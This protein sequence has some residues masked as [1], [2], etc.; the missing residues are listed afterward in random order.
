M[1]AT[2][3]RPNPDE[4]LVRVQAEERQEARGKLQ[5]FLGYAAGVG[6]TYAMLEAARQ[7]EAQGVD[8]VVG[9]VETHG[10]A[11]TD[12]LLTGL[13]IIPRRQVEYRQTTV[14]EMDMDAVLARRPQLALVDEFAHTNAP[15]S[16]HP[17][18]YHD[19][20]E[21]LEAGIDVYTTLNI[22]HLESLND[23]VAQ[24]T[25]VVVRETLPDS[26]LD[27]AA[28]ITLVDLPPDELIQRLHDG[29]VYVPDTAA[30]A[31]ERFFR[32]GNLTALREMALRRAAGRVDEQMLAYM[33]TRAIL[34]PWPAGERLLVCVSTSSLGERLVRSARRLADE[35]GAEWSAIHVETGESRRAPEEMR[36]RVTRTLRLAED[37]GAKVVT[38]PGSSVAG[39]VLDYARTH[40]IT[41]II[42]G[43]PLRSR[44][45]EWLRGAIVDQLIRSSGPID[46][47]VVSSE[48]QASSGKSGDW[49]P[50]R[51]W[52]R[53]LQSTLLVAAA[54]LVS[55]PFS[56]L[57]SPVN[58][59]MLYLVVVVVSAVFLGRG[60]SILAS[61]LS[62]LAFDF[63]FVPPHL[64]FAV[65]DTEYILTFIG[66]FLVGLVISTLATRAREQADAARFSAEQ[67]TELYELSRDLAAVYGLDDILRALIRH[68]QGTFGREGVI[69]LPDHGR[70]ASTVGNG[71]LEL[72]ENELAVGD[73]VL[74]H[75]EPAGRNT[76][77]LPGAQLRYLPLKTAR[78]VL[79]VLGIRGS[80]EVDRYLTPEQERLMEAFAS[81]A[82]VAIERAQ[83]AEQAR[84]AQVLQGAE[85]LQT[86]LLNSISHDLRTPLVSIT[87]ALSSLQDQDAQLDGVSRR[88]LIENAREE[89]E[90]LNRLVGNL[91]DMSRVEAGA[92][93]LR[94]EPSDVQ[95]VIGSALAQLDEP[96]RGR[97]VRVDVP[98]GLPLVPMDFALMTRVLVNLL[99]NAI[100]Y[101]PPG[102]PIE[103]ETKVAAGHLEIDVSDR[104]VGVP[105]ED[106]SR[107][108]DKF[109]RVQRPGRV[110]GSGLGLSI[111]KGIVEAHQGF[112]AAENRPGGGTTI[113]IC[114]PERGGGRGMSQDALR[115]LVVDDEP[116]IQR[117]LNTALSAEGYSVFA[118][119]SGAEALAAVVAHRPDLIVLDLGLPDMDGSEVTRRVREW[120]SVPIIILSVR[121]QEGDKIEALDAGAD[122]YLAKPFSVGELLARMRVGLRPSDPFHHRAALR[123]G[124]AL[125][126]PCAAHG[127]GRREGGAAYTHGVRHPAAP[128][129]PCRDGADPSPDLARGV[130]C[131]LR[132]GGPHAAGQHQQLATQDRGGSLTATLCRV[133]ARSWL[134][135]EGGGIELLTHF[136]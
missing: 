50:H 134:P 73:W 135:P 104:G 39:S 25:G 88:R 1:S 117:F 58:L 133:R 42:A 14:T 46:V 16:R 103:V 41:K 116:A 78:G 71:E 123:V 59:V 70:L 136:R 31:V 62:V 91:L 9:Y 93:R 106:L 63:F 6:K 87:G 128:G 57:I 102:S 107:V 45:H 101:S 48:A 127:D 40:N 126:R 32:K 69:L 51:P 131:R 12:A 53:Y 11:E 8:V 64:T 33:Q 60:P 37:L 115:V 61:V 112:I 34:G 47:Y 79:G 82:A 118:A 15:G 111:C 110:V 124:G 100:K 30:V 68:I 90:R 29:K 130:G 28:E 105:H 114:L 99:D 108:F 86:A 38:I 20:H 26:V 83:L 98:D 84:Q 75:G 120:A 125:G 27:E 72:N 113:T 7:R 77:T 129:E 67:T 109:Y 5:V 119:A 43:K 66:L 3:I 35:L 21:L 94:L 122:D 92:L 95:D 10:R 56:L 89:A 96:L 44:W 19:V 49:L 55:V 2:F 85:Q 76:N 36:A 4:L 52:R 65:S 24:I 74:R 81:Q 13:E 17:K 22:Q 54:T 121:G 23:A 80:G 132:K 18:R 97:R